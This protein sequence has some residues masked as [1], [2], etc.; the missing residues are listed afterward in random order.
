MHVTDQR[1]HGCKDKG[2]VG[3]TVTEQERGRLITVCPANE[4]VRCLH[5]CSR[6]GAE[7]APVQVWHL[8]GE[9]W[10]SRRLEDGGVS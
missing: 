1:A 5:V 2:G 6:S 7:E 10:R 8:H 4:F 3:S 9:D